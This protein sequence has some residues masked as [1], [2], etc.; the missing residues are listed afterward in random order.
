MHACIMWSSLLHASMMNSAR[1]FE[2]CRF[3]A[4][5]AELNRQGKSHAVIDLVDGR[6]YATNDA[7]ISEYI[8]ALVRTDR[9]RAYAE[10]PTRWA[11]DPTCR[12]P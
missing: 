4:L 7:V 10:A 9:L 2:H 3:H 12:R 5:V 11:S 6:D 8:T 1:A